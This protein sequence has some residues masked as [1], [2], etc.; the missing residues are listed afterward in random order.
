MFKT[1]DSVFND[2]ASSIWY[3]PFV[4]TLVHQCIV[5]GTGDKTYRPETSMTRID[6]AYALAHAHELVPRCA[7]DQVCAEKLGKCAECDPDKF[8]QKCSDD[9]AKVQA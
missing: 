7:T 4:Q 8:E 1:Y 5:S 3:Y 9:K 6:F 2:V